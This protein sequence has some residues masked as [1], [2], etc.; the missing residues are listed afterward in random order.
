[1]ADSETKQDDNSASVDGKKKRSRVLQED[2]PSSSLEQAM[3]VPRAIADN[4][5]YKPTR[6]LNV[7]EAIGMTPTSGSFRL[8]TGAAAAYGLTTG[9]AQ[10][11]EI[12]L[13]PI[14][15]RIVRPTSEGD[16]IVAK[17]EALLQPKIIGDFLRRY[18]GA[19]MPPDNIA[20]NVLQEM[21]VP[22]DRAEKVLVQ[23]TEDAQALGFI[24]EWSGKRYVDLASPEREAAAGKDAAED[25]SEEGENSLEALAVPVAT[26]P[27]RASTTEV[28]VNPARNSPSV[29]MNAGINVNVE[30][31]I[32]ADASTETIEDIFR[33]MR[34]YILSDGGSGDEVDG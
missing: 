15:L 28:Q 25:S 16:D 7:A 32:A 9:A 34:R 17:R 18:D 8:I 6:S 21:G 20:K 23:I 30:I 14:G 12:G 31:H 1:M 19:A 27:P 22:A 11:P 29:S 2:V 26:V 4:Y 24:R 5:A 33:N 10:A 13:T 3:R